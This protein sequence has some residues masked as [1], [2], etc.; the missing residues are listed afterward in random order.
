MDKGAVEKLIGNI[1]DQSK[2]PIKNFYE[3][4]LITGTSLS[5]GK[6]EEFKDLIFTGKYVSGLKKVLAGRT[7]NN[8]KYI[9][10][11]FE[12]FNQNL[13]KVI[14]LMK[15]IIEDTGEPEKKFFNEKYFLMNHKSIVNTMELIEDL[16]LCK[17]YFN[18]NPNAIL[19]L[20]FRHSS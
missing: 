19:G 10:K 15:N 7:I 9:E 6:Q 16:S 11:M 17:E 13:Q 4:S 2:C 18:N 5:Q 14:D 8:D 1:N 12:E 3:I 20:S